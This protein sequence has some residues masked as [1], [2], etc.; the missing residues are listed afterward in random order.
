MDLTKFKKMAVDD[1]VHPELP[2][3]H[4]LQVLLH[5]ELCDFFSYKRLLEYR[6]GF[7]LDNFQFSSY[8]EVEQYFINYVKPHI[9]SSNESQEIVPGREE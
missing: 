9:V 4:R 6:L 5:A 3:D 2:S 7:I 8:D 1:I